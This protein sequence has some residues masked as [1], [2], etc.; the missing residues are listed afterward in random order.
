MFEKNKKRLVNIT[1]FGM[2]L[3]VWRRVGPLSV[4]DDGLH[5]QAQSRQHNAYHK[6]QASKGI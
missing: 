1:H 4:D 2:K 5:P 6:G 3:N